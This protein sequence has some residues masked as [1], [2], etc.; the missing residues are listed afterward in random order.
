[1]IMSQ[2]PLGIL[3]YIKLLLTRV[4]R[5]EINEVFMKKKE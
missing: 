2:L 3:N 1:M 5:H 4:K